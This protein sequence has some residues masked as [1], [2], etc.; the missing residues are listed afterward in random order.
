MP[1]H[2]LDT[3]VYSQRL[4]PQPLPGVIRRWQILGNEALAVSAI[5]ESEIIYGLSKKKSARLWTEYRTYLEHRLVMLP[6]D[7]RVADCFG[8][9]K[10]E[11]ESKGMPRADF[12]LLIAATAVVHGLILATCNARHFTDI[13]GLRVE[14]WSGDQP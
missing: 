8:E 11:M 2:L 1:T 12:D 7:K 4:R 9:L 14:D 6:V 13:P 5:C 3:S 10:A